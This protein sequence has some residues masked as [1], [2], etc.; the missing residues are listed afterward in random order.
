MSECSVCGVK[1]FKTREPKQRNCTKCGKLVCPSHYYFSVDG[2]NRAITKALGHLGLCLD[3]A[4]PEK[5]LF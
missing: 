5:E 4:N 1:L 2:N 3:C